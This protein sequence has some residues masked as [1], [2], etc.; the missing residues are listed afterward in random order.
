M[1]IGF[2]SGRF[3]AFV[4]LLVAGSTGKKVVHPVAPGGKQIAP[5]AGFYIYQFFFMPDFGKNILYQL[6]GGQF[7][8]YQG[9]YIVIQSFTVLPVE[10]GESCSTAP[11]KLQY[12]R[13][14]VV[15]LIWNACSHVKDI[16]YDKDAI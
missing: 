6:L 5:K 14:L 9:K 12:E 15:A 7:I 16:G 3:N 10:L 11:L 2:G 13:L 8:F 1:A 4:Q